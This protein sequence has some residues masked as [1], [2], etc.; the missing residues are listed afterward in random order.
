MIAYWLTS[1]CGIVRSAMLEKI[2][3]AFVKRPIYRSENSAHNRDTVNLQVLLLY[4][5]SPRFLEHKDQAACRVHP[6][7]LP[8]DRVRSIR[9]VALSQPGR[10]PGV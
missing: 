6:H 9:E 7:V 8:A 4:E 5:A 2:Q 3:D 1:D 10:V